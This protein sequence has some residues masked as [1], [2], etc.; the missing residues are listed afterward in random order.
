MALA[1]GELWVDVSRYWD[2]FWWLDGVNAGAFADVG[3]TWYS[4]AALARAETVGDRSEPDPQASAGWALDIE[5][6]RIHVARRLGD[7]DAGW[8]VSFRVSRTF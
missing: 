8:D 7:A 4:D 1:N 6:L 5:D 2:R 3:T